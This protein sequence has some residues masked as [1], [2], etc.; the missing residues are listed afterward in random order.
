[1][2]QW[3]YLK[4]DLNHTPRRGDPIDV[5][6]KAGTDGWELVAV[7]GNGIATLKREIV[8]PA[9]GGR[10]KAVEEVAG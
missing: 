9:K 10:R 6:N 3:E 2:R 5:L 8:Q 7:T 1:V 4:L